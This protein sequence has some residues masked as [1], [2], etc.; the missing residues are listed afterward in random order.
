MWSSPGGG[1]GAVPLIGSGQA[2][3]AVSPFTVRGMH[4]D[5]GTTI[6]IDRPAQDGWALLTDYG[7]DP[8]WRAGVLFMRA[9]PP[10]GAA[11]GTTTAEV[12]RFADRTLHNDGEIVRVGPGHE[13]AWRTTSGLDAQACA[14]WNRAARSA[15]GYG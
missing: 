11:P 5:F 1:P 12:M 3:L 10:G 2:D 7:R 6:V 8:E 4:I 9:E 15:A 14:P 13:L